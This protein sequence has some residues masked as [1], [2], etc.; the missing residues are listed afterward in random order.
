MAQQGGR[1]ALQMAIFKGHDD[2]ARLLL[3]NHRRTGLD[4]N[5]QDTVRFIRLL[6][7][8]QPC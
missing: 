4:L 2:V 7:H 5:S 8:L 1:S 6:R 3:A